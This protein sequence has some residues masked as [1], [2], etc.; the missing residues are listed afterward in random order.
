[1]IFSR[2]HHDDDMTVNVVSDHSPS[3]DALRMH[4]VSEL[5]RVAC[6]QPSAHI[7]G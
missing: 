7:L 1:M 3:L 5:A 2:T 6:S 4:A